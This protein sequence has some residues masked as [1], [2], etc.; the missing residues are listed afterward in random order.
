MLA[1]V[2]NSEQLQLRKFP[3]LAPGK[4]PEPVL[5]NKVGRDYTGR[6][7]AVLHKASNTLVV[8]TSG[9]VRFIAGGGTGKQ[10]HLISQSS[11]LINCLTLWTPL[12]KGE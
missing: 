8:Q 7:K 9:Q 12:W 11:C 2:T 4:V 6:D 3:H 1:C 5:V 10:T